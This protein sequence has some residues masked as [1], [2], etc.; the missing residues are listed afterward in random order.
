MIGLVYE[1]PSWDRIVV[2]EYVDTR[3]QADLL[4]WEE[5]L[6]GQGCV[7]LPEQGSD[8]VS[9]SFDPFTQ[10]DIGGGL[11][12]LLGATPEEQKP[13]LTT[14]EWIQPFDRTKA[15]AEL[16][17]EF[18]LVVGIQGYASTFS[19]DEAVAF[20]KQMVASQGSEHQEG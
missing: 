5:K 12:A 11:V 7:A 18:Q 9:C 4:A 8:A 16:G 14:V 15:G 20:A 3:T 10:V 6:V 17:P 1:D 13:A 2:F 19:P